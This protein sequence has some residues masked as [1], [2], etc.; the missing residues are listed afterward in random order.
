MRTTWEPHL[1]PRSGEQ[2]TVPRAPFRH[3]PA[4]PS[5]RLTNVPTSTVAPVQRP[6]VPS[7]SSAMRLSFS[8]CWGTAFSHG[9]VFGIS[10]LNR[11]GLV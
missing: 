9:T 6:S 11:R 1:P 3:I 7:E 4:L 2:R 5:H 8:R 10:A